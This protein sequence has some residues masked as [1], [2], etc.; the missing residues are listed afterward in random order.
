MTESN[1][2]TYHGI[3][4][5]GSLVVDFVTV[6]LTCMLW[7]WMLTRGSVSLMPVTEDVEDAKGKS[8]AKELKAEKKAEKKQE[9]KQEKKDKKVKVP[10]A[11]KPVALTDEGFSS[12][13][14]P[15]SHPALSP[16]QNAPFKPEVNGDEDMSRDLVSSV[17]SRRSWNGGMG[18]QDY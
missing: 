6:I 1:A 7:A 17:E 2:W 15:S 10:K 11:S 12:R 9:K 3:A 18:D 4:F 16:D 8:M 5:G 13:V 14:V